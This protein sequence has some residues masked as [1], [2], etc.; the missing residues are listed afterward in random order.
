M[1]TRW[2][3]RQLLL[4]AF[5]VL[6][7]LDKTV[8]NIMLNSVLPGELARDMQAN[9]ENILRLN[10][11]SLLLTMV[12]SMGE[13]MPIT[14]LGMT[15]FGFGTSQFNSQFV[16]D[17]LGTSFL[18]FLLK[19]IEDPPEIDEDEQ[20]PELFVNLIL[21]YNLQFKSPKEN[22]V[23]DALEHRNIAKVF[24]EKILLLLNREGKQLPLFFTL[25]LHCFFFRRRP[26]E[27]F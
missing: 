18:N 11:S 10:Y 20:I 6:C 26:R 4:H 8:V 25:Y 2:S 24:T 14:H 13:P 22:V 12:F 9:T 1:E 3:L 23:L 19:F 7:N 27:S 15:L 5:G 16:L 17:L 21:S